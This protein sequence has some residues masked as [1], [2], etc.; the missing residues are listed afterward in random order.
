MS[1]FL[2]PELIVQLNFPTGE[3]PILFSVFQ[4]FQMASKEKSILTLASFSAVPRSHND[5]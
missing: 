1:I 5:P 4:L 3:Q 2:L